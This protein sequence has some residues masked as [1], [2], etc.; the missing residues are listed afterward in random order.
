MS[1]MRTAPTLY[2]SR[3]TPP[4]RQVSGRVLDIATKL[5]PNANQPLK[6]LRAGDRTHAEAIQL[7]GPT[8]YEGM[9]PEW[10]STKMPPLIATEDSMAQW[11]TH[12]APSMTLWKLGQT[13]AL[14][15]DHGDAVILRAHGP[16]KPVEVFQRHSFAPASQQSAEPA[17]MSISWFTTVTLG[18]HAT[19][20]AASA[21]YLGS[22]DGAR[23]FLRLAPTTGTAFSNIPDTESFADILTAQFHYLTELPWYSLGEVGRNPIDTQSDGTYIART[24]TGRGFASYRLNSQQSDHTYARLGF[25]G[26]PEIPEESPHTLN[27]LFQ[28]LEFHAGQNDLVVNS[29]LFPYANTVKFR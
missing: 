14:T 16:D 10:P 3:M 12:G 24:N 27:G 23:Q 2:S 4:S 13:I 5:R 26:L 18:D 29:L 11:A 15:S 21:D 1:S 9:H 22:Y 19:L 6:P 25:Y 17:R 20:K 8:F 28:Y 7:T